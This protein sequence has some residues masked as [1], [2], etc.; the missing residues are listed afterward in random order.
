MDISLDGWDIGT[1][2]DLDWSPWGSGGDARAKVLGSA[3]GFFVAVVEAEPGYSGDPHEH[4]HP[5]FLYV[6]DGTLDNQGR[7]M[8]AGDGYAAAPGST[9]AQFATATGATYLSIFK[10]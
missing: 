5:E 3:D 1:F 2:D 9:H 7:T 6:I 10:L 8:T 4:A